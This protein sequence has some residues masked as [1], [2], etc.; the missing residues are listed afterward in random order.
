MITLKAIARATA[1]FQAARLIQ[2]KA[3]ESGGAAELFAILGTNLYGII[4]EQ[5]DTR[6]WRSLPARIHL[7]R[8][9]LPPGKHSFTLKVLH[10]GQEDSHEFT[11]VEVQEGKKQFLEWAVY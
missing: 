2:Q 7:A 10:A 8:M 5:A 1:K 9:A 3:K 6:S 11:D 4:S